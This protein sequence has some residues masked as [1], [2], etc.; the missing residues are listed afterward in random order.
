MNINYEFSDMIGS[1]YKN[2]NAAFLGPHTVVAPVGNKIK[3]FN[4]KENNSWTLPVQSSYNIVI[5]EI[6]PSGK[7]AFIVNEV[8][9]GMF[10]NLVHGTVLYRMRFGDKVKVVKFSPDGKR[11]AVC[12]SG[13]L[14]IYRTT[15]KVHG[16]FN[17]FALVQIRKLSTDHIRCL[18]W[19][20][21]S[22]LLVCGGDDKNL[23]IVDPNKKLA[24]LTA[25]G[26][27]GH[28][29][30][31]IGCYFLNRETLDV[32]SIDDRGELYTWTCELSPHDLVD[33]SDNE[34]ANEE[35]EMI[36]YTR[37]SKDKV[38]KHLDGNVYEMQ[39][40]S[41]CYNPKTKIMSVGY[42]HGVF[43][44]LEMPSGIVIQNMRASDFKIST[45]ALN[46][47]GD[48]LAIGCGEG[49]NSQLI[50]W[51]WQSESYILKQQS[52]SQA[53][54]AAAF[55]PDGSLLA[56]GAEDGKVKIWNTS[57][58]FCVVTFTEH[59]AGVSAIAW[60]QSGKAIVSASLDGTI[61]AHDIK[62]YRNFRTMTCPR[63]TSLGCV[64]VDDASELVVASSKE[65]FEVYIFS[66]DTGDMID[67]F[68]GHSSVITKMSIS[69]SNLATISLD[70][71]MRVFNI[72]DQSQ[73][74]RI[75]LPNEGLD[76]K[77]S[78]CGKLIAALT[79]DSAITFFDANTRAEIGTID[80][81]IDV[82]SSRLAGEVIKKTTSEKNKSFTCISFSPDSLLI[83][84]GGQSNFFCL[85]SVPDRMLIRKFML[86]L[87]RSLD[88]V[89]LDIDYRKITEFGN[90]EN[91]E[92]SDEE[93]DH[94]PGSRKRRT[95]LPG[96]E[97]SDN[98]ERSFMPVMRVNA[99][100]FNPTCRSFAVVST[101]GIA[102]YSLDNKRRFDPFEL[103]LDVHPKAVHQALENNEFP[104]ALSMSLRLAK[105]E[106]I[107]RVICSIHWERV[108]FVVS[109]LSITYVEKL[110]KVFAD[111]Y[112]FLFG[113]QFHLFQKWFN[114]I[115]I[116]HGG[117]LKTATG[118]SRQQ[119]VAALTA[120]QHI[121]SV[122][123]QQVFA[124]VEE[125]A[126]TLDYILAMRQLKK[127]D[128][129]GEDESDPE[130]EII[131]LDSD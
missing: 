110:L 95:K 54:L 79:Y 118:S 84:A 10:I 31:I 37:G 98:G 127:V 53:V 91:F 11:L 56:T 131:E 48:W 87:N 55:S 26:I 104:K 5:L 43:L 12:T 7:H 81:R 72:V 75:N 89:R 49:S 22:K 100:D 44:L 20:Y 14:H 88:G 125:V 71:T 113:T 124:P 109:Q 85:Y 38:T 52:H 130:P 27:S 90:L 97:K 83:L 73:F 45:L 40:T 28:R 122:Q 108:K 67:N 50:V 9:I 115:L 36:N 116:V 106:L 78:P 82:D 80:T 103:S 76:V 96:T 107:K 1:S 18:S 93:N 16:L 68:S 120:L 112:H 63:Q 42:A 15:F 24:N 105:L 47:S 129:Y 60:T 35:V 123:T 99:I 13:K 69:G 70:Q 30:R 41:A 33:K 21:D 86:T 77:F 29:G 51:E 8:G 19:S 119:I 4:I 111:E 102:V 58:S 66:L 128:L 92:S 32:C 65:L 94:L 126:N 6:S 46:D 117:A 61:R 17:P 74:E 23:W 3:V 101:E 34:A 62:R 39:L 59:T 2:G 64:I 114:A 121:I 57:S 25:Y